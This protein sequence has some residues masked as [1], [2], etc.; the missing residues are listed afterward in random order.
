MSTGQE[1]TVD[2]RAS[3]RVPV[4]FTVHC[5]RRG[6]N[7]FA[8]DAEVVDLSMGGIRITARERLDVGNVVEIVV[9]EG[10]DELTLSGLVVATTPQRARTRYAHIAFTRLESS[11]LERIGAL[12]DAHASS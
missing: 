2:R 8:Q 9:G 4:R 3:R 1:R 10:S 7:G 12:V 11:T 5:R 6:P